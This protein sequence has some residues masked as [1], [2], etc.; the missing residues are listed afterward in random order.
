M[1]ARSGPTH[2]AA[3]LRRSC[4]MLHRSSS[5]FLRVSHLLLVV[6]AS[7][8][9]AG[10]LAV[11]ASNGVTGPRTGEWA[12]ERSA[13][14][15]A[16]EVKWGRLDNGFRYALL[17]HDGV[18]GRVALRLMVLT[19]SLD[20]TDQER[21]IAHFLEHMAFR[22]TKSFTTEEQVEFFQR[23]G[24]DPNSDVNARTGHEETVYMIE[25]REQTPA[26]LDEALRWMRDVADGV[27]FTPDE[28]EEERGVILSE[29]RVGNDVGRRGVEAAFPVQLKGLRTPERS[30]IGTQATI[31]A[32]QR[33]DFLKFYQRNYRSDLMI[34]VASGDFSA[35]GFEPMVRSRFESLVRPAMPVPSRDIGRLD[36]SKGL[37]AGV[38]SVTDVGQASGVVGYAEPAPDRPDSH[39]GRLEMWRREF[40]FEVFGQRA[41]REVGGLAMF[42]RQ[43]GHYLSMAVGAIVNEDWAHDLGVLDDLVRY[44]IQKGFSAGEIDTIK[45]RHRTRADF[46]LEQ[47]DVMDPA[48]LAESVVDAISNHEVYVGL[49]QEQRWKRDWLAKLS[50]KEVNDAFARSWD[51]D[52][53]AFF[54]TGNI[55]VEGGGAT[56]VKKMQEARRGGL[57]SFRAQS[58]KESVFKLPTWGEPTGVVES[59]DVPEFG[60]KLMRFGNNVR[61]N[62]ASNRSDPGVVH[63]LARFGT[64][65][66]EM[67]EHLPALKDVALQTLISSGT[68]HF[69]NE[70]L[71]TIIQDHVG[72]IGLDLDENDAFAFRAFAEPDKLEIP[73]AILTD[74]LHRPVFGTFTHR[75]EKFKAAI[76]RHLGGRG[77]PD[78]ER[79]LRDYL[80]RGDPRFES[81]DDAKTYLGLSAVDV[82][83]WLQQPLTRGYLEVTIVGDISEEEVVR[84]VSRT[85]GSLP[86]RAETKTLTYPPKPIAISAPPGFKRIEFI[87]EQH[88]GQAAGVWPIQEKISIRDHAA[89]LVL[90]KV[91]QQHVFAEIRS[92][93]GLAYS[94]NVGLQRFSGFPNFALMRARVQCDPGET[95]R[96]ATLL[97]DIAAHLAEGG[98]T[99]AE[100]TGARGILSGH[101]RFEMHENGFLISMLRRAQENPES[102]ASA[103]SLKDGLIDE[104]TF[105]EVNAWAKRILP[106]TN[107]R[108]AAISPKQFIGIF[109][110][111]E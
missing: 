31:R 74:T 26:L 75:E 19:G 87:G 21:G 46:M 13:L 47:K 83:D 100:F 70:Q 60:A 62:F 5:E 90:S 36:T 55:Q 2:F 81:V 84:V 105:E 6:A 61:L 34:L 57:R 104:I 35:A 24:M 59:R 11:A 72:D 52:R 51:V 66:L 95:S 97:E 108:T 77:I 30:P 54:I 3:D 110:T 58:R 48:G 14:K 102:L 29:L 65:V 88:L 111:G 67:P 69:T 33:S 15:P 50:P 85:L 4:L 73:L 25:F 38:F 53:M 49:E 89:L 20:E 56:I 45:R 109:Q 101:T 7:L 103:I 76:H 12:H 32:F 86:P 41:A 18:P 27:L 93:L 79:Q 9:L 99:E 16:P 1:P 96:V 98:M 39:E 44:S 71:G 64:G 80:F 63:V 37:R 107:S 43:T 40:A 82:R 10:P 17:P 22:D 42:R 8:V 91:L 68:T 78:G 23:L 28:I 92:R 94:P 106:R